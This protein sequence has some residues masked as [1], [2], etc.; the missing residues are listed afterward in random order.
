[1]RLKI[2]P[3]P[4]NETTWIVDIGFDISWDQVSKVV[5]TITTQRKSFSKA[6]LDDIIS[7]L[8]RM[9][10]VEEYFE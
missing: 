7:E 4:E 6:L 10:K 8:E 5:L 9:K 2:E 3:E 1:M